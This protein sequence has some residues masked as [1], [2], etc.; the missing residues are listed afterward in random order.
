M[1]KKKKRAAKSGAAR[2]RKKTAAKKKTAKKT[3]AVKRKAVPKKKKTTAAKKSTSQTRPGGAPVKR[4]VKPAEEEIP[5][6][7][8]L[9]KQAVPLEPKDVELDEEVGEEEL[10]I[11]GEGEMDDEMEED[12]P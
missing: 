6:Q 7:K 10:E 4:V 5:K 3:R 8:T 1:A 9:A 11:A 2:A 12:L